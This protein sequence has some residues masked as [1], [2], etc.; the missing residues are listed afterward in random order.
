MQDVHLAIASVSTAGDVSVPGGAPRVHAWSC[1]AS[2]AGVAVPEEAV[3]AEA[4]PQAAASSPQDRPSA[5][6]SEAGNALL[7]S[8]SAHTD[9]DLGEDMLRRLSGAST[10]LLPR[11]SRGLPPADAPYPLVDAPTDALHLPAPSAEV[12]ARRQQEPTATLGSSDSPREYSNWGSPLES[13]SFSRYTSPRDAAARERSS[14]DGT[15][16]FTPRSLVSSDASPLAYE[17][18]AMARHADAAACAPSYAAPTASFLAYQQA[19]RDEPARDAQRVSTPSNVRERADA[20]PQTV[21]FSRGRPLG[22][23]VER[24]TAAEPT[25]TRALPCASCLLSSHAQTQY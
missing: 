16:L 1:E 8:V 25:P 3:P 12:T 22:E 20:G 17:A 19:A 4:A 14:L 2:L 15:E 7:T 11:R 23:G 6:T 13:A 21:R 9:F 24:P 5:V 10:D 18:I